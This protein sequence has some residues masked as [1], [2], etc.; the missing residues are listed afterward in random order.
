MDDRAKHERCV[1]EWLA[2]QPRGDSEVAVEQF[3][4]ASAALWECSSETLGDVTVAAIA[5][6]VLLV[7]TER[8]PVLAPL[9]VLPSRGIQA[10]E[11]L[12]SEDTR[13]EQ[14]LAAGL[15]FVLIETLSVLGNLTG[16]ILNQELHATFDPPRVRTPRSDGA[17]KRRRK[18]GAK[19]TAAN[20]KSRRRS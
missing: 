19:R 10:P 2:R 20:K 5:E 12:V 17:G 16:G 8:F 15:R 11:D 18:P 1:D 3:N 9:A 6:R 4:E 14:R 7:S 13:S